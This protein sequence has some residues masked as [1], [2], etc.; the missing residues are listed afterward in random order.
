MVGTIGFAGGKARK[1][2]TTGRWLLRLGLNHLAFSV[3]GGALTGLVFA[4]LG[5]LLQELLGSPGSIVAVTMFATL[6]AA[7]ILMLPI[8]RLSHARQVPM[9]WKHV[10][11]APMSAALYGLVLGVGVLTAVYYWSFAA[12]TLGIALSATPVIGLAAGGSF[13]LGRALPVLL[14]ALAQDEHSVEQ[15]SDAVRDFASNHTRVVRLTSAG[16]TILPVLPSLPA[17][18]QILRLG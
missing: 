2:K 15:W 16:A 17:A 7:D 9:S 1:G 14:S 6:A 10:F 5:S 12:L 3:I 13:G 4:F 11:P 8:T 18:A